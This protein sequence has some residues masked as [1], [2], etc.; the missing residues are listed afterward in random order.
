MESTPSILTRKYFIYA[1]GAVTSNLNHNM[2]YFGLKT[3]WSINQSLNQSIKQSI[4]INA[5]HHLVYAYTHTRFRRGCCIG[6]MR[7]LACIGRTANMQASSWP[8]SSKADTSSCQW[9]EVFRNGHCLIKGK[10]TSDNHA[11]KPVIARKVYEHID[12]PTT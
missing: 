5:Y 9:N 2:C 3:F 4:L 6:S 12:D 10:V 11:R 8:I 1:I 7:I